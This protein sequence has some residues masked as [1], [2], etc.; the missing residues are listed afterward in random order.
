[1][2]ERLSAPSEEQETLQYS[3][4]QLVLR[5]TG[6]TGAVFDW[7]KHKWGPHHVGN[8]AILMTESGN[9]Y[10]FHNAP[11]E[12][13]V[14]NIG[15]TMKTKKLVGA[16]NPNYNAEL[17]AV[18]FHRSYQIPGFYGT[19]PVREVLLRYYKV[20]SK[21]QPLGREIAQPSPFAQYRELLKEQYGFVEDEN[22]FHY[23]RQ[24]FGNA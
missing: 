19:T 17:P 9:A 13:Y 24:V 23:P 14:V 11:Q 4:G 1:M 10:Y 12:L 8:E 15:E 21:D 5:Y 3:D 6:E 16:S 7:G 22:G 2:T 20:A 18:E